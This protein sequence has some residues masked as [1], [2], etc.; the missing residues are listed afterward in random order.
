MVQ[1][2]IVLKYIANS[3]GKTKRTGGEDEGDWM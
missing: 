1:R 3:L 2:Q